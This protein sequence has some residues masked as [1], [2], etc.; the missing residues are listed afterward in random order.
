[1]KLGA[2]TLTPETFF[3]KFSSRSDWL[4][5]PARGG[6]RVKQLDWTAKSRRTQSLFRIGTDDSKKQPSFFSV[7]FSKA[8]G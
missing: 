4:F 8:H 6:A 1:L 2:Q 3:W 7:W 5:F